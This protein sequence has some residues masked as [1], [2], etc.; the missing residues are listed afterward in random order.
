MLFRLK[1]VDSGSTTFTPWFTE[2]STNVTQVVSQ[3]RIDYPN[4]AI[5]IERKIGVPIGP[6]PPTPYSLTGDPNPTLGAD[7]QLAGHGIIGQLEKETLVLDGGLL[8]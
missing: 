5:S 7:L 6:P 1:V 3:T 2:T 8:G 4:S